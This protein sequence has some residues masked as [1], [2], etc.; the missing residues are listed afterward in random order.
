M[1]KIENQLL[2][3]IYDN[4]IISQ[5]QLSNIMSCSLGLINKSLNHLKDLGYLNTNYNLTEIGKNMINENKPNN[6]IILAAGL[7]MRMTPINNNISKGLIVVNNQTL[8]ENIINT[9]K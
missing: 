9:L 6:A 4:G 7:G 8:I 2:L 1:N 5:R 3:Y